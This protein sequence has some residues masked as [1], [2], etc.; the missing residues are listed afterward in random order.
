[1]H[2]RDCAG[3]QSR[4]WG[5]TIGGQSAGGSRRR[6]AEKRVDEAQG[7]PRVVGNVDE[8]EHPPDTVEEPSR[9]AITSARGRGTSGR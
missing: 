2:W 6:A 5:R 3:K 9:W 7:R 4:A 8:G 1:M